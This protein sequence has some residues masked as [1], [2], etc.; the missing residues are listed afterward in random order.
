MS[1]AQNGYA[2]VVLTLIEKGADVNAKRNDTGHTVLMA[3]VMNGNEEI[4]YALL[5]SG[6]KLNAKRSDGVT[7]MECAAENGHTNIVQILKNHKNTSNVVNIKQTQALSYT[8][9]AHSRIKPAT[10]RTADLPPLS[11]FSEFMYFLDTRFKPIEWADYF[12]S[13]EELCDLVELYSELL[14]RAGAK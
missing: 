3:A 6:A 4:V 13:P 1:A 7:V 12:I 2:D 10:H 8:N 11:S 14:I 9:I 5:T